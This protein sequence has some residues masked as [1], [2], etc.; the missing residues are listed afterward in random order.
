MLIMQSEYLRFTP[1]ESLFTVKPSVILLG[2]TSTTLDSESFSKEQWQEINAVT[3]IASQA[4]RTCYSPTIKTPL[5]QINGS[6]TYRD[7][8]RLITADTKKAGHNTTREHVNYLFALSDVSRNF[9]HSVLHA[10][11]HGVSDMESQRYVAMTREGLMLPQN[12]MMVTSGSKM[13]DAY[14]EITPLLVPLIEKEYYSRFP[15]RENATAEINKLATETARMVLPI[16]FRTNLYHT[17]NALTLKRYYA[18]K[19]TYDIGPEAT[20]VIGL[21]VDAVLA[22]DPS[23]ADEL[24]DPRVI[25]PNAVEGSYSSADE[26]DSLLAGHPTLL[27][28]TDPHIIA[29]LSQAIRLTLGKSKAELPDAEALA[30]V[31]D[32]KKNP[33]L[34]S[35]LGE[36]TTDQLSESLNHVSPS[37]LVSISHAGDSQL[38]RH[39]GLNHTRLIHP[40]VP[41]LGHDIYIPPLIAASPQALEIFLTTLSNT[42]SIQESL[43]NEAVPASQI[44]YLDSN[45]TLQRVMITGPLGPFFH[46]LKSRTCL[47]AQKEIYDIA[48]SIT[49][50]LPKSLKSYF[51]KPAHCGVRT[52]ADITPYCSEGSHFCG[53]PIWQKNISDYPPRLI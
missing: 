28:V 12:E 22:I 51:D 5:H 4:A 36:I 8:S 42:I 21:M 41:R 43:A 10:H 20:Q 7:K 15:K 48:V 33:L 26:F 18:L 13:I 1:K 6:N 46:F 32:P 25:I 52:Q 34:A 17:V 9:T 50:Q 40:P 19:E 14:K 24:N 16:G 31:L 49:K 29:R 27:E 53:L 37:A 11:P 2:V 23:F 47:T 39:R 3:T 38:Q 35:T 45:A 30:L 44:H